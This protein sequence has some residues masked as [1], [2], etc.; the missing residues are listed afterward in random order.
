[1]NEVGALSLAA[2][3]PCLVGATS[4]KSV[5]QDRSFAASIDP[6]TASES[7]VGKLCNASKHSISLAP[8][9]WCEKYASASARDRSA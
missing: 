7:F 8:R 5:R 3:F 2:R 6:R 1:M 4:R 9:T